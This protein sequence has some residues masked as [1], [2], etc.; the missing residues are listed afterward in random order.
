MPQETVY[1]YNSTDG[2]LAWPSPMT[3]EEA[4]AFIREFPKRFARQGHYTTATGERI[5]PVDVE[6]TLLDENW[7]PVRS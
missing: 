5:K 4:R 3:L 2:I 1:V 7:E 6:L